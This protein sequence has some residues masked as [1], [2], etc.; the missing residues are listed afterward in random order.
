MSDKTASFDI[1]LVD[2]HAHFFEKRFPLAPTAWHVPENESP[3]SA[4]VALL[5][6]HGI[7]YGVLAGASVYGDFNDYALEATRKHKHLRTTLSVN[8]TIDPY[9]LKAMKEDGAVGIRFQ[10]MH[11]DVPDLTTFD[12]RK[13]FYRVAD[14]NWHVHL[15]DHGNR[16]HASLPQLLESGVDLVIDHFG[17]P[18]AE[19]GVNCEGFQAVLK[20]CETGRVWVKIASA[21]R[22]ASPD[23]ADE[24][25]ASLIANVG[26][27]R[28]LWGSDWPFANFED[29][30]T[31][32]Q[33][34]ADF[35]RFIPTPEL[36]EQIGGTT[37]MALY[38]RD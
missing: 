3:L 30:V 18:D 6:K 34:L 29:Q 13:L 9:A 31:Y 10:F 37:P 16:L 19:K 28:L 35:K 36:R 27:E 7:K 24:L 2:C 1:P 22:L 25:A 32:D 20:A 38:F 33:M 21:F 17:R 12:Y 8:P 5:E 15:H 4:Y 23:L 26:P 14:L 11:H